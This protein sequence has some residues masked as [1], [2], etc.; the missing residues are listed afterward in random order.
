M[1]KIIVN[2]GPCED[3]IAKSLASIRAQTYS[4]WEAFV[5]VDP[6]GDQTLDR[7]LEARADDTRISIISNQH[8][9]YS[10]TNLIN[11]I[12]RSA[13]QPEDIIVNLDGDDWFYDND[14]LQIIAD[15]YARYDCWMT[16]GSWISHVAYTPERFPAYAEGT[17][18]FR[19]TE[20]LAT[21]VRT[22]KK[23][24]WDLVDLEDLKDEQGEYFRVAEDLAVIFPMLEM[25]GTGKAK[26]I[27][28]ILMLHNRTDPALMDELKKK[29]IERVG[30]YIRTRPRY[31]Q[32]PNKPISK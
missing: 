23:W 22:F 7:A 8:R 32:L 5:T 15:T 1:M 27:P 4:N 6:C 12:E 21:A 26:K 17:N 19:A 20:W 13:A 29:E 28:D 3:Y 24:L 16:Y 2:C 10:L 25:S 18:D 9:L 30:R 31:E 11:A 14:A